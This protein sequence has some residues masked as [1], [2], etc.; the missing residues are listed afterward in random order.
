LGS[1][2]GNTGRTYWHGKNFALN[3]KG[4]PNEGLGCYEAHI[5]RMQRIAH[6]AGKKLIVNVAGFTP[7]E[8]AELTVRCYEAGAD[9]VEQNYGCP[10]H[11]HGSEQQRIFSFDPESLAESLRL[12]TLG[13]G[14]ER[15]VL[16]KLSPYSDPVLLAEVA[17]CLAQFP[18]VGGVVSVNT[19][20]NAFSFAR[21]G[22]ASITYGKGLAGMSGPAL[23]P[24]S[25]GQVMQL[26]EK[27]PDTVQI[28]GVGGITTPDDAMDYIRAGAD[29][30]QIGTAWL[31]NGLGVFNA[32]ADKFEQQLAGV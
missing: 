19:F 30:I 13:I 9:L 29:A 14:K 10:N 5:P 18:V 17:T 27:L 28:V 3:S 7:E 22:S 25:L 8:Y 21:D 1:R 26:R 31:E 12:T 16:T 6:A 24:I 11:W 2:K 32:V 20:P 4:L 15:K 23:K